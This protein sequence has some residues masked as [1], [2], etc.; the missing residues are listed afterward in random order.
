MWP[1]E[2]APLFIP[3]WIKCALFTP[4]DVN[5]F[6][7]SGFPTESLNWVGEPDYRFPNIPVSESLKKLLVS[8]DGLLGPGPGV[9]LVLVMVVVLSQSL[10]NKDLDVIQIAVCISSQVTLTYH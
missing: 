8:V 4:C 2:C 6:L 3:T 1:G 9:V 10:V 5:F 7:E